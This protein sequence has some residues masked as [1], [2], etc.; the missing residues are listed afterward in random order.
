M[1]SFQESLREK[2][3]QVNRGSSSDTQMYKVR[4]YQRGE[5]LDN[6]PHFAV[7]PAALSFVSSPPL[8]SQVF[9]ESYVSVTR[10]A[11]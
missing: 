11:A 10:R 3:V 1:M 9:G 8:P 7:D 2:A 6:I 4:N 5:Q